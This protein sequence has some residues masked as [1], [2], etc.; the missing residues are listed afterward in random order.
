MGLYGDAM[1]KLDDG[2]FISKIQPGK[3]LRVRLLDYPHIAQKQ[4]T[5]GDG[6]VNLATQFYWPVW[7]YEQ[8]R[9]RILQQGKSVFTQIGKASEKW[10]RGEE[11]PSPFDIIIERTGTGKNDTRYVVTAV[12]HG[13]GMD[14]KQT[15][16]K[17]LPDMEKLSGGI[18]L[19]QI[20]AG[21]KPEVQVIGN[22]SDPSTGLPS[23][24]TRSNDVVI[25]DL[26]ADQDINL[27]GILF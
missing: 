5:D 2:M 18:P 23:G 20:V 8:S 16:P 27:D 4:F 15:D 26:D 13:E 17:Y 12:P 7:D 14:L 19:K 25:K 9:V 10:D 22:G 1:N 11:F 6:E 21:E 24:E 3:D